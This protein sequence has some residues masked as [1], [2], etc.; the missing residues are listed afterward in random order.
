MRRPWLLRLCL[1]HRLS[2]KDWALTL[3]PALLWIAGTHARQYLIHPRCVG[4]D[5]GAECSKTNVPS[6]DQPGLGMENMRA[7]AYSYTT[8]NVS[9]YL[10]I[11]AAV[12]WSGGAVLTNLSTPL[13]AA[14]AAG[15]DLVLLGQAASWNGVF[16]EICHVIAH[17]PRPFVY[18]DPGGRGQDPA[19]YTSFYSGHT[20]FA[21]VAGVSL[22]LILLARGAP[23]GL[24]IFSASISQ[25]LVMSTGLFRIL[26]GRH[27]LTDVVA[28]ACFGSL[29]ALA[30]F[31]CHKPPAA[32]G[33]LA[34]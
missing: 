19:H 22:F 16:N 7:D 4:P 33:P 5:A 26:S 14:I 13:T 21:A 32:D 29:I 34:S 20:S 1:P 3:I 8:Q 2:R 28:A 15:T 25:G 31:L 10:A 24:L 27:F 17:R 23:A 30:V 12:L 9:G 6:I 18:S 11:G